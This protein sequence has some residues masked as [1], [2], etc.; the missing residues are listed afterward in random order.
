MIVLW[1]INLILTKENL[2]HTLFW[3][4][5]KLTDY[6]GISYASV[7]SQHEFWRIITYGYTQTAIWHLLGFGLGYLFGYF[8]KGDS[9]CIASSKMNHEF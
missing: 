1:M 5:G 6:T 7:F 2:I 4:G 9:N 3:G 8:I